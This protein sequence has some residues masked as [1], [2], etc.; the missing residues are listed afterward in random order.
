MAYLFQ[1]AEKIRQTDIA[2]I[3]LQIPPN[4]ELEIKDGIDFA[5]KL[6]QVNPFIKLIVITN[7]T[8][9]SI[10]LKAYRELNPSAIIIK[11]E[12]TMDTLNQALQ[13][14]LDGKTYWSNT[15]NQI[16]KS[17]LNAE[18]SFS[19]EDYKLLEL[20]SNGIP[21]KDIPLHLPWSVSKIEK[22]KK[23]LREALNIES[24]SVLKLVAMAR[25]KGLIS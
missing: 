2:F 15:F 3:D 11:S 25:Q 19:E 16:I 17:V 5:K 20:L 23:K 21:T 9:H 24:K 14:T 22:R 7:E 13:L 1:S 4:L 12:M 8:S 6:V 10:L 18:N